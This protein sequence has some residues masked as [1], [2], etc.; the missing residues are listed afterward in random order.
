MPPTLKL[1]RCRAQNSSPLVT[2]RG[3]AE[4]RYFAFEAEFAV[5]GP[6]GAPAVPSLVECAGL[7][8]RPGASK[9]VYVSIGLVQLLRGIISSIHQFGARHPLCFIAEDALPEGSTN[10]RR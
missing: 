1:T 8:F 2:N 3:F 10:S 5:A 9:F 4:S 6:P 7:Q